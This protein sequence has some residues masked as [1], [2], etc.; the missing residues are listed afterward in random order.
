MTETLSLVD[1]TL[2]DGRRVDVGIRGETITS[3]RAPGEAPSG[4]VLDGKG[5]LCVRPFTDSHL[6]LDKAGTAGVGSEAPTSVKQAIEMMRAIK[7]RDRDHPDQLY[8]RMIEMLKRLR[9]KGTAFVRAVID[10]D[11]TWGLSAFHAAVR[12][13]RDMAGRVEVRIVAFPQEGLSPKVADLLREAA[14]SGADAIG[15]HTDIDADVRAHLTAAAAIAR[16]AHLPLEVHV[17]EAASPSSFH[18]PLALELTG[19]VQSLSLVHN[20]SLATLPGS[21]Q[22]EWIAQIRNRRATVV[23]AP[24]ILRFGLPLAPISRLLQGGVRVVL[25]SD[26]LQDVFVPLGTGSMLDSVRIAALVGGLTTPQLV[27][28]LFSGATTGGYELVHG[29]PDGIG[30]ESPANLLVFSSPDP[31]SIVRGDDAIR[32]TILGGQVSESNESR[33]GDSR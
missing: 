27:S 12:A 6:H 24:S 3:I 21:A 29:G 18:L 5:G 28:A 17:D 10:V 9:A 14:E 31:L 19:D 7:L 22:E 2:L 26:N 32:F 25:G 30:P 33:T 15:A 20:L 4:R 13:R 1:V 11:E 8:A 23:I 16:E